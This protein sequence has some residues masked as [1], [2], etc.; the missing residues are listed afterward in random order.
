MCWYSLKLTGA[1]IAVWVVWC[2][3]TAFVYR[4]VLGFQRKLIAANNEE[5]GLVQQI[6]SG[7]SKFR[8]HGAEEQAYHLWSKVFGETWKWN[9]ALRWQGNYNT[10]IAAVQPFILTMLLYYIVIY[11]MQETVNDG[12]GVKVVQSGIGYA[13]FLA[14]EAAFSSFNA[15]LNAVIPLVGT[16]FTIQPHIENLRPILEEVPENTEDKQEAEPLSGAI[17]V[18]HL[19]FAYIT[20]IRCMLMYGV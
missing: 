1:A 10:I 17:E 2:L 9:L 8:V 5:A 19:T 7:L 20:T 11:G 6:F 12:N 15:T 16:F 14:F 3:L 13:Q 4:R 18:S